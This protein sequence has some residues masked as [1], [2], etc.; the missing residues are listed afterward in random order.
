MKLSDLAKRIVGSR[1]LGARDVEVAR[2]VHDSRQVRPGDLFVALPGTRVDGHRFVQAALEA[3]ASAA[4]VERPVPLPLNPAL[5][6]V[7]DA[8]E[9]LGVAAHALAGD[10]T[11][12][13]T[14]VGVTGTNGKTTTTYLVRSILEKAGQGTGLLGTIGYR[15]GE[16]WIPSRMTTPD[17]M[18][19]ASYFAE[20]AESGL[21]AAVMEVSSH[22]L[23]QRRT[24]GIRFQVG[25][26]T[27]LTPE[28]LDYH[29]DMPSYR[30]A[31]GRLFADLAP[32]AWAVLNADDEASRS[33]AEATRARV[34]WYGLDEPADVRAEEVVTDLG[35][36]RFA[37]CVPRGRAAVRTPLL[38]RHNVLNCLTAAAIAEALAVPLEAV[39]AGIGALATVR[40]RLE[41][42]PSDRPFTVLVDYAHTA[43]ALENAL[44][45]VRALGPRRVIL[46]FGCGGNRDRQKRPEMAKVA[47]K[48]A[49]RMIVTNDNPRKE[50]PQAIAEEILNGFSS[51]EAATVELD[52][53]RAIALAL[54]EA[55]EGD[56][57]LIAGKGHETYQETREGTFPFDDREVAGGILSGGDGG[58][59]T[60]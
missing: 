30:Q 51:R 55:R 47:E 23:D 40:G 25:A 14:V 32:E 12:R 58:P 10:P 42:V 19:L 60:A 5:L 43:D 52:R 11:E 3:G 35:G 34:L 38:G 41:P 53:R 15:I 16:R 4:M 46:V 6:V 39:V 48:L 33:F 1:V 27:N 57:V 31:K 21:E 20:M 24:A 28:H 54:G 49:D 7:P 56:V 9:A 2:A 17:A 59:A 50:D 8:R 18:D 37:L 22:A 29:K 26:F 44:E 13:L 45:A 36:S